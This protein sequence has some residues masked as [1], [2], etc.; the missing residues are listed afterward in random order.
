M[1]SW[2]T[3]SALFALLTAAA[4]AVSA[5]TIKPYQAQEVKPYQAQEVKP[6]QAQQIKPYQAQEIKP[7]QAQEVKPYRA[8]DSGAQHAQPPQ[9]G[10]GISSLLGL[11]QT[12]I[13]GVAYTTPSSQAGYDILHVSP[14]APGGLFMLNANGTY[15]WNSY[16]GKRGK[17]VQTG[18]SDYPVEIIDTVEKRRWLVG[19]DGRT[20]EITLWSGSFWYKGRR[21]A[22]K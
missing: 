5:Q 21:A 7:Y 10:G 16:G 3:K 2:E 17:W 15:S 13:P 19:L 20:G 18:R 14:G 8:A 9:K 4:A 22:M 11:W 12:N 6:Y 1:M